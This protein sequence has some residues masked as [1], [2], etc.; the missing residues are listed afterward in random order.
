MESQKRQVAH[1]ICI[2]DIVEGKYITE[3]GWQPNYIITKDEKKISRVNVIGTIVLKTNGE[4]INYNGLVLDDGTGKIS[5]RSFD[6]KNPLLNFNIGEII[7][8][9][10]KLREYGQEKYIIPEVIKKIKN[11][12]WV[13]LR[14][15]ELGRKI[16]H[17]KNEIYKTKKEAQIENVVLDEEIVK[18]NNTVSSSEKILTLVK[19]LDAGSGTDIQELINKSS[20]DKAESIIKTLL[21]QGEIFEIKPG[22]LKILE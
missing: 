20:I 13:E 16:N 5:I 22:K 7:L 10:G 2:K 11:K 17:S 15:L 19:K 9:I 18:E 21:E 8:L 1:K 12:P 14:K 3:E 4:N 6:E